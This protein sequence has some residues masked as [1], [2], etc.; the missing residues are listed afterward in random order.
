LVLT[1][2]DDGSAVLRVIPS[3]DAGGLRLLLEGELDGSTAGQLVDAA[4]AELAGA[5]PAGTCPDLCLDLA[6]LEFV[7]VSGLRSL[8]AVR[9]QVRDGGGRLRVSGARPFARRLLQL[10]GLA[11][12]L[13][14]QPAG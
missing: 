13:E 10:T 7:D 6:E 11:E 2:T 9:A 1:L 12:V 14:Q 3:R 4:A 8:A 5:A